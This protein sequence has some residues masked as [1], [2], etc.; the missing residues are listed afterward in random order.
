[1]DATAWATFWAFMGLLVLIGIMIYVKVPQR[2]IEALDNRAATIRTQL[3]DARRLREEAQA[4]LAEYQR[5]RREAESEA[6]DIVN[7]A[8]READAIAADAREKMQD[9]IE[10]RT[11][12][13]EQRI[14]QA[15][16]QAIAEVR[17]R[18]VDVAT[19]AAARILAERAEG[20]AGRALIDSSI[21]A[22]RKNLN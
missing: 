8:R 19:A 13:V 2:I 17:G 3:D 20:D 12:G 16:A 6:E 5:R 11:R 1:M 22:V 18:A 14:A 10:R 9:Y 15:E 7:Q 4:L 21:T